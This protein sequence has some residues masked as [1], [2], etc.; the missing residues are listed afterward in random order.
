MDEM[1]CFPLNSYRSI[2]KFLVL[3]FLWP[4]LSQGKTPTRI[5]CLGDSL[6]AGFGVSKAQAYPALL[7][8]KLNAKGYDVIVIN[9]GISGSTT[10]SG[11]SRLTWHLKA[12][13]K[14][15]ILLLA[16]GANDGLR[17]IDLK[18]SEQN[19]AKVIDLATASKI[20][21]LLAGMKIPPNYGKKYTAEFEA[22]F[23]TLGET[24]KISRIPFLLEGVAAKPELNLADGIH[25]NAKGYE[26]VTETIIKYLAPMLKK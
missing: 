20:R 8:Q 6:T 24:K 25:P 13:D 11:L 5:L 3:F 15:D 2:F 17:G 21:V 26:I 1:L 10:S 7:E 4:P 23:K 12:K 19:L 14:L 18:S 9:G 22:L 16:L